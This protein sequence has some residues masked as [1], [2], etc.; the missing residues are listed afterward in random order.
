MSGR[1]DFPPQ[2]QVSIP[3]PATSVIE[4]GR[5][6]IAKIFTLN[7]FHHHQKLL[8]SIAKEFVKMTYIELKKTTRLRRKSMF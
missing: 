6:I 7:G 5:V 1:H 8:P 3:G 2:K 4:N